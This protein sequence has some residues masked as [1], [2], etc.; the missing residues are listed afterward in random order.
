[1]SVGVCETEMNKPMTRL[2][3]YLVMRRDQLRSADLCESRGRVVQV[4]GLIIESEGPMAGVG[5][6]CQVIHPKTKSATMCEVVGFRSHRV[7]LMP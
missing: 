4:I 5:E 2:S 7:L 6:I 1:M 3:E